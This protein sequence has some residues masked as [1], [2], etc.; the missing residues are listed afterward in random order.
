MLSGPLNSNIRRLQLMLFIVKFE[1]RQDK[2]KARSE[3]LAA[4]IQWL[5]EHAES[6]LVGGSLRAELGAH[7][8]R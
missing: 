1:D 6:V 5:A 4:H 2:A 8:E 3:N 7:V